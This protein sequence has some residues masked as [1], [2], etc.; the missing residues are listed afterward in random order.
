LQQAAQACQ[1]AAGDRLASAQAQLSAVESE[2]A[3]LSALLADIRQSLGVNGRAAAIDAALRDAEA[4]LSIAEAFVDTI[5]NRAQDGASCTATARQ[6]AVV[7]AD[8]PTPDES[9]GSWG[10]SLEKARR[11]R[12]S[13]A[14]PPS[15]STDPRGASEPAVNIDEQLRSAISAYSRCDYVGAAGYLNQARARFAGDPRVDR[16]RVLVNRQA[17]AEATYRQAVAQRSVALA[18]RAVQDAGAPELAPPC[19]LAKA[20][21]LVNRLQAG[22]VIEDALAERERQ[23]RKWDRW[24]DEFA[25]TMIGLL[26]EINRAQRGEAPLPGPSTPLTSGGSGGGSRGG[27]GGKV[28]EV[29]DAGGNGNDI[30]FVVW[31]GDETGSLYAVYALRHHTESQRR[32][33]NCSSTRDCLAGYLRQE[34][35]RRRIVGSSYST[36]AEALRAANAECGR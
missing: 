28:C 8:V 18:Q 17:R 5:R 13:S 16:M 14:E 4:T 29:R 10:D 25:G 2:V 23:Q 30:F 27:A 35:P 33:G 7:P 26:G 15:D 36:K 21:N 3:G 11:Q 22:Q 9:G 34:N 20:K 32:R 1:T 31:D 19:Q 12:S 24:G 6:K